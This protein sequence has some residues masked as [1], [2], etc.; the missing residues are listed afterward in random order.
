[1]KAILVDDEP[2]AL[3]YLERQLNKVS[4]IVVVGKFTNL[5]IGKETTL[6]EEVDVV[7]L[8]IEMAGV[9]GLELAEQILEINS[10][11]SIIFVTAFKDYAVKAFELNAFDYILKP[12]QL[13][14]LQLT[15]ERIEKKLDDQI[16]QPLSVNQILQI[17]VCRELT[18]YFTK[19]KVEIIHW[20]TTKAQELFLYLL[21]HSGKA[22]RKSE[23]IDILWAEFDQNKA[24]AQLYNAIYHVRKTLGKFSNHFSLKS[25]PDGY[26]LLT[27]NALIDIL[28]WE[29]RIVAAPPISMETV[30]GY[31]T[32]M[33]LYTGSYLQ[34]YDYLWVEP[35]RYRLELLWT[36]VAYQL[37]NFYYEQGEL[38]NA[39]IW[40]VKICTIRPEE[41][42]AHF[43][44]MKLFA[45]LGND[46]L[47]DYQYVQLKNALEELSIQV[48]PNIR[49]WYDQWNQNKTISKP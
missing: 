45:I 46:K 9:N 14:R 27:K 26:I 33:D 36:N 48:S 2:L 10:S 16:S 29:N 11:L 41:E 24:Y 35:E 37:A 8:D 20:R 15:L 25:V 21:H 43:S 49:K 28:E 42:N 47:V 3:D 18:F 12:V 23:L 38:K 30:D 34:E 6:L 4:N 19:D 7:F 17:N 31:E 22:I 44:L 13:E 39:R 1:M 5:I 32:S 40:Y